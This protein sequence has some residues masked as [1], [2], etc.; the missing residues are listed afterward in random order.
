MRR[1]R[2]ALS[3]DVRVLPDGGTAMLEPCGTGWPR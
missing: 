1:D 2:E 3:A